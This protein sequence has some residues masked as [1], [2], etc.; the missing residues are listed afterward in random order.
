V[1]VRGTV[2]KAAV[3]GLLC[4]VIPVSA[5]SGA[6]ADAGDAHSY[7]ADAAVPVAVRGT[8]SKVVV[9]LLLCCYTSSVPCHVRGADNYSADT[10][11]P[12]AV[13]GTVSKGVVLG[14]YTSAVLC[15]VF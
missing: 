12:V 15:H 9:L 4:S 1:A 5:G 7:A 6:A 8:V 10:A 14:W 2:S 13:H 11:V 3:A